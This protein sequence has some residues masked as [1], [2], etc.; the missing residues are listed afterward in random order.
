MH[1]FCLFVCF[2]VVSFVIL[3]IPHY[4]SLLV[5]LASFQYF[6]RLNLIVLCRLCQLSGSC[7]L[8]F[9]SWECYGLCQGHKPT[10]LAHSFLFRSCVCFCPCPFNCI[11][12]HKFSEQLS[13]LSPCSS[14][15]NS[16]LLVLST[17]YLFMK[18]SLSPDIILCGWLGLKHQL[19][20]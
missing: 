7:G 8:T 4:H 20:N 3:W 11:S 10:E 6:S 17:I 12:F 2:L 18:V 14:G 1:E 9:S 13:A 16:A 5:E 19:T 15:H